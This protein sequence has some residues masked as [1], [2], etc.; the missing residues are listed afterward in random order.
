MRRV[1]GLTIAV[2]MV[3]AAPWV[4][5][6]SED[7]KDSLQQTLRGQVTLTTLTA[8]R[9]DIAAAGTLSPPPGTPSSLVTQF[10]HPTLSSRHAAA[11]LAQLIILGSAP[12]IQNRGYRTLA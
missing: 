4:H 2:V 7:P 5:G 9:S 12:Q 3:G 8:D 6:Q 10:M 1:A 11:R